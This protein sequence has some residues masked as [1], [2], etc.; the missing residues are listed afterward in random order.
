[1]KLYEKPPCRPQKWV[2]VGGQRFFS[3]SIW[4]H[5]YA[6]ILEKRRLMGIIA[7][8]K[9]EP[10]TFW[11]E[12][13]RRGVCS[14]KPDFLVTYPDGSEEYHEVK[15][16]MDRKSKTKLTRMAKYHPNVKVVLV[17]EKSYRAIMRRG[18]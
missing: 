13:I 15:G 1:M 17:D 7:S 8:W 16:F 3:R 11:F 5:H 2:T 9:H 6:E 12:G 18:I 10:K 14:Y 4:E